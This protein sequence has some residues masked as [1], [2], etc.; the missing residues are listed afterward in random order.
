MPPRR[1]GAHGPAR[2][3]DTPTRDLSLD[4]VLDRLVSH[5]A[6]DAM[7]VMGPTGAEGGRLGPASDYDLLVVLKEFTLPLRLVVTSVDH[8]G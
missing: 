4:E 3:G 1:S 6:V 7:L 8:L 2:M 5:A